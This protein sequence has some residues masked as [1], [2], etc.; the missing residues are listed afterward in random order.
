MGLLCKQD[1]DFILL[2]YSI[3]VYV[4][5]LS[6]YWHRQDW[7]QVKCL[8]LTWL[9]YLWCNPPPPSP[10]AFERGR[11]GIFCFSSYKLLHTY[12]EIHWRSSLSL[13]HTH[14]HTHTPTHLHPPPPHSAS[15]NPIY[16]A[17]LL[18]LFFSTYTSSIHHRLNNH[19]SFS[20][21]LV[22][23]EH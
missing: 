6:R 3:I 2:E 10:P 11:K 13:T 7:H 8:P 4:Y 19:F 21:I 16:Q 22:M 5:R 20:L 1:H 12:S 14:T 17:S 15:P 18:F 9:I 23:F